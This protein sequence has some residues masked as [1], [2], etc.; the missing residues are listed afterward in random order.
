MKRLFRPIE[1]AFAFAVA[2]CVQVG[3]LVLLALGDAK[4]VRADLSDENSRPIAVA[5]TPE[6]DL[7]EGELKGAGATKKNVPSMWQRKAPQNNSALP[8]TKAD[9]SLAGLTSA[10]VLADAGPPSDAIGDAIELPF[11]AGSGGDANGPF[12]FPDGGKAPDEEEARAIVLYRGQIGGWFSSRFDIRGKVPFD[13]LQKLRATVVFEI[14]VADR[15]VISYDVVKG[16]GNEV[17]DDQLYRNMA[18]VV[19]SKAV[20]PPPPDKYPNLLH[21]RETVVFSCT[22]QTQCE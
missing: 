20:L 18:S 3:F 7:P 10:K 22:V 12:G 1:I 13:T 8:S 14:S 15:T 21:G 19:A 9:P 6:L 11:E 4:P 2:I 5:I 17:F 16:S